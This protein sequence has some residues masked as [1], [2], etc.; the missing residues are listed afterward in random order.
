[1]WVALQHETG[2]ER[3]ALYRSLSPPSSPDVIFFVM[4]VQQ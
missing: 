1:L 2:A 4:E 3:V